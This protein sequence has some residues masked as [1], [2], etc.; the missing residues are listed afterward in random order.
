MSNDKLLIS[1]LKLTLDFFEFLKG[2]LNALAD[3]IGVEVM[4]SSKFA[5]TYGM[6]LKTPSNKSAYLEI[7]TQSG[8]G[9]FEYNK[10]NFAVYRPMALTLPLHFYSP[11][12]SLKNLNNP[13]KDNRST[14]FWKPDLISQKDKPSTVSFLH[15]TGLA[16]TF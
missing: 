10:M 4:Y 14:S 2:K 9:L 1:K 3:V 16:N 11:R 15:P 6:Q 5:N 7:T 13:S 8:N 12:Y